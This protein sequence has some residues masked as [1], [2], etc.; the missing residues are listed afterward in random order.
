MTQKNRN[1][2]I[3]SR[4]IVLLTISSLSV[5]GR[6][7]MKEVGQRLK[8]LR[9]EHSY[10]QT[11]VAEYLGIDQS[12]LSKIERGERNF[13]LSSLIKLCSLYNCSQDYILCRSD[14]YD[15]SNIAFRTDGKVDLNVIAKANETMNYLKLL[16]KIEKKNVN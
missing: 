2:Y 10:S 14:E 16:R 6:E 9:E 3:L 12:N 4:S 1:I 15:K 8:Q 11:Q 5:F 13:K 7:F